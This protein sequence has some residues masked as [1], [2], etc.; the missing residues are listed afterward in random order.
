MYF[1]FKVTFNKVFNKQSGGV[2]SPTVISTLS[3]NYIW[4]YHLIVSEIN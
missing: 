4:H 3:I 1:N 2:C